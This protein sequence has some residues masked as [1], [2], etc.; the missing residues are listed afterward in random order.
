MWFGYADKTRG[1]MTRLVLEGLQ[2]F[3][4]SPAEV[5]RT[6]T[7]DAAGLLNIDHLSG[8]LEPGS[9]AD[10]IAVDGDPLAD[11]RSLEKISFVMKEGAV[12]RASFSQ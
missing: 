1:Q 10:L 7:V 2:T 12:I 4:L 11:V 8:A 5:L 6:A 9:Y 3:G